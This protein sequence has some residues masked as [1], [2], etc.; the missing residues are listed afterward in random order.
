MLERYSRPQMRAI[1]TQ[2]NQYR[3]W[4]RVELAAAEV[5]AELG[6]VPQEAWAQIRER[7]DFTVEGVAAREAATRH[8][9]VAFLEEVIAHVGEEAGRYLHLGLT[10]SDVKDTG[11]ALQLVAALDILLNEADDCVAALKARALAERNTIMVGRTH[12]VHAEPV[13]LGLTLALWAFEMARNRERLARAREIAAV[14]KL[15]GPVGA[16]T[17]VDPEIERRVCERLELRPASISSQVLQRDRQAE[18]MWACAITAA[19]VEKIATQV[20]IWSRT[21]LGEVEEPFRAGQRGSSAMPH[22]RN[23]IL[24]ERLSGLARL[25]RGWLVAALEDVALWDQRDMTHSSVERFILPDAT[26]TLDYMLDRLRELIETMV[27]YPERMA[28]NLARTQGLIGS[29]QVLLAL[30]ERG[31][32]RQEA[33]ERVQRAAMAAWR[34]EGHFAALLADDEVIASFISPEELNGLLDPTAMLR[35]VNEVFERLQEV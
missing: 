2:E 17:S 30:V 27:V 13:T 33:Y 28:A 8:D 3:Q 24:S 23:P 21:E 29:Q 14:G 15:S 16:Y 5:M 25:F 34:G 12:G 22:K 7:A 6:R 11:L 10:S 19:T 35:H 20:R 32:G 9:L 18:V 26:I 1:W 31:M 4:L